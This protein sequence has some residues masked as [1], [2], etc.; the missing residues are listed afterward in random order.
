M[1]TEKEIVIEIKNFNGWYAQKQALKDINMEIKKKKVSAI[2]GPSGCGK[3]TLLR[4][5]NRIN[6]EIPGYRTN[7]EIIF[8]GKNIYENNIDLSLLRKKIGMVFQK[9]VPFPMTIY[10]NI[11]F[12]V[13]LHTKRNGRKM[14]AIVETALKRAALWDE[15]KDDLDKPASS[16]SGGQQQRLCIARAIAVDPEIILLDEPTS[17]LDPIA[18][19]KIENLIEHLSENYTIII[20][21]H[22]L[23]QAIRISDYMYFMFQGELIES[24]KTEDI[25]KS[26]K[27]QLTEDYLNGRIS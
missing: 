1:S 9:P 12:G 15:V 17:A 18:T 23:A 10:E 6:D 4:S 2:I 27:E 7:G 14:D 26:P 20:V 11:A 8:D 3:S 22:N 24:G 13:K 25:I 5:I 16:L 19:Q 21:T